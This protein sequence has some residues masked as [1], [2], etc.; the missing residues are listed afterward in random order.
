MTGK[1]FGGLCFFSAVILL[2]LWVTYDTIRAFGFDAGHEHGVCDQVCNAHARV[3]EPY[4][5]KCLCP[6]DHVIVVK[7]KP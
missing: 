3:L 6:N 1:E 7:G 4:P 5:L 2:G